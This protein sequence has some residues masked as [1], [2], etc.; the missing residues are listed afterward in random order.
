MTMTATQ[1]LVTVATFDLPMSAVVV[2]NALAADGIP[3]VVTDGD[4]SALLS[5]DTVGGAKVQVPARFAAEA[6]HKIAA[7]EVAGGTDTFDAQE[8]ERMALA[9]PPESL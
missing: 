4:V 2:R 3:A 9:S 6:A 7:Y 1:E 5:G 8:L